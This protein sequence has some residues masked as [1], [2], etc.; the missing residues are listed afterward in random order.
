MVI[1]EPKTIREMDGCFGNLPENIYF[2]GKF[3]EHFMAICY[4]DIHI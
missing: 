4:Q 2:C 3:S 1:G